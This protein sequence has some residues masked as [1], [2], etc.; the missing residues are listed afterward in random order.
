MKNIFKRGEKG[1]TLIEIMIVL[2]V[3]AILAAVI[4]PNVSG[5]L[6]RAK[7]RAWEADRNVLQA[8]VDSYRTDIAK[9]SG[10]PWPLI[11]GPPWVL[12]IPTVVTD[13]TAIDASKG[14]IDIAKLYNASDP[15]KNY[16][17]G[18]DSVKSALQAANFATGTTGLSTIDG[19]YV[20]YVDADGV[21]KSVL[22]D[23][24]LAVSIIDLTKKDFQTN[25][26]P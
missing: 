18:L 5:Y 21:V 17:K 7:E 22:Y 4:I 2:A 9:R 13:K 3:M 26:Y 8:A 24:N 11:T 23:R 19:S 20:W 10:N 1:F 12:G 16:L 14:V 6:G 15:T 25:V